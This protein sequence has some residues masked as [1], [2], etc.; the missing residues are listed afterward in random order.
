MTRCFPPLPI[1]DVSILFPP[2]S[3]VTFAQHFCE[4]SIKYV[5]RGSYLVHAEFRE[6]SFHSSAPN[7]KWVLNLHV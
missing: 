1:D 4:I 2:I 7:V 5:L 6:I 3:N